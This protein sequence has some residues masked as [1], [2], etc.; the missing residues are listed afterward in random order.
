[1]KR[2]AVFQVIFSLIATALFITGIVLFSLDEGAVYGST[3]V[4]SGFI[5]LFLGIYFSRK[6]RKS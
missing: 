5:F 2:N 6:D 1:M 3:A 4:S